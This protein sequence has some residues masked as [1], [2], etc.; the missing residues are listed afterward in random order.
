VIIYIVTAEG[1]AITELDKKIIA[2][3]EK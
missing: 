2:L 1:F 3:K